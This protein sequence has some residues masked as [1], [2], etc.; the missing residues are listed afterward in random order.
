MGIAANPLF[1]QVTTDNND[2]PDVYAYSDV[3]ALVNLDQFD[4]TP[5]PLTQ[6]NG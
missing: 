3:A 5:S 6:I 4:Y 1:T 2:L